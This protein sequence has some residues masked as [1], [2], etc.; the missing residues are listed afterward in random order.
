MTYKLIALLGALTLL[1]ACSVT[2]NN[3]EVLP[4][5]LP[6]A[7]DYQLVDGDYLPISLAELA[8]QLQDR[9][10]VFIGEYHGNHASHLLEMQLLAALHRIDPSLVLSME[11]FT[12]DQ[13]G[14]LDD[15]I[16]GA[17]GERYLIKE[18]PAW[19]NYRASYRPLVEYAKQ[20]A[21]PV[22][23]ANA[24]GDIVRCIGHQGADYID[25]LS[26][27]EARYLAAQPFAEVPGYEER[28]LGFMVGSKHSPGPRQHQSYLAQL[29]RDNTMA[30]SIAQALEQ[31]PN[32]RVLHLNGSFHS[33]D[34]LGTVGA[35][36]R[37][38]PGLKVTVITPIYLE[39]FAEAKQQNNRKDDFYYLINPL[40]QEFV[41][42]GYRKKAYKEM[43]GKAKEKA[44]QALQVAHG[45]PKHPSY[46]AP[47]ISPR[48]LASSGLLANGS[49]C[50]DH[51]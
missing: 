29:A 50:L 41:D 17:I 22:I 36:K 23:A 1:C 32:S 25:K 37:L 38:N 15:Y 42:S 46:R 33:E 24:S 7:Y 27:Q 18:A 40:P 43:F 35:L 48:G 8:G 34:H 26:G 19:K 3:G 49:P 9:D 10:V 39:D 47:F 16:D 51:N 11:M 14:I 44:Q 45:Y 28:F 4:G 20:N 6:T 13:Q 31:S 12:R 2:P 30:E 5:K 21:I